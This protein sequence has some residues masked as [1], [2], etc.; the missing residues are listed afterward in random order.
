MAASLLLLSMVQYVVRVEPDD[1][2]AT[3][4]NGCVCSHSRSSKVCHVI[5]NTNSYTFSNNNIIDPLHI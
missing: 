2:R 5:P 3:M 1:I 4:R